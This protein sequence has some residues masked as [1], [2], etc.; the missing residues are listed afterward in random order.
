MP[1]GLPSTYDISHDQALDLAAARLD[2]P[3]EYVEE[4]KLTRHLGA[5]SDCADGAE[6]LREDKA[7]IVDVPEDDDEEELEED[8][9][10]SDEPEPDPRSDEDDAD[11]EFDK[12]STEPGPP[13]LD[14]DDF[15]DEDD[16]DEDDKDGEND[17]PPATDDDDDFEDDA[18]APPQGDDADNAA[19]D[20]AAADDAATDDEKSSV[21]DDD[22]ASDDEP[23]GAASADLE[24]ASDDAAA[25][26][27]TDEDLGSL[28]D[29][30][31]AFPTCAA[32]GVEESAAANGAQHG[33]YLRKQAEDAV[34]A[35]RDLEDD[36]HGNRVDVC[37]STKGLLGRGNRGYYRPVASGA[38]ASQI[39]NAILRSRTGHTGIERHQPRGRLD[40]KGLHRIAMQDMRLFHR[41]NAPSPGKFLVWVMVDCSGSMSGRP[42]TDAAEVAHALA[43]A[44][45]GAPTVRLA[46][47]GWSD[48]FRASSRGAG[49]YAGVAKVWETSKPTTDVFNLVDLPMGGTPDSIVLNWAWR[50]ISRECRTDEQ[51]VI[52]LCS[53]G[54]G[55]GPLDKIVEAASKHGVEVKSVSMGQAVKPEVQEHNFGRGNFVEW[56]GS[57]LATARPLATMIGRMASGQ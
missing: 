41:R 35:G 21:A 33:D 53:D 13:P 28:E 2:F 34:R 50:A 14:A 1:A 52:I 32:D 39:R 31:E 27:M 45:T 48:P 10:E 37:K 51:P 24:D 19:A 6:S 49:A 5:C 7:V 9:F 38:A 22:A 18:A 56:G 3:L 40:S 15:E 12:V 47:W 57:V 26:A 42:I 4:L 25:D 55:Y 16:K 20:D 23:T 46:V 17:S 30:D 11:D 8:D 29:E 44:S 36:G 43:E 54:W